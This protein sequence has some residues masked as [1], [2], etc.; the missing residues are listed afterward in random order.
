M[1]KRLTYSHDEFFRDTFARQET[2]LDFLQHY[3]P[4]QLRELVYLPSLTINKDSFIDPELQPHYADLL[5]HLDWV[6]STAKTEKQTGLYLYL[7]FEHK[8]HPDE[9]VPLQLLTYQ[10]QIWALWRKQQAQMKTKPL[11]NKLPPILPIVFYHGTSKWQ[12]ARNF[13]ALFDLPAPLRPHVPEFTYL[14]Y[15]LSEYSDTEIIG[16]VY[17]RARLLLMKY[18]LRDELIDKLDEIFGL[19]RGLEQAETGM[20]H[21]IVMLRYLVSGVNAEQKTVL[22]EKVNQAML[23][24]N[25]MM[26]IADA[27][28]AEGEAKGRAAGEAKGRLDSIRR[29][30]A[31]RFEIP[32]DQFDPQL[33]SLD[34]AALTELSEIMFE[35]ANLTEFEAALKRLTSSSKGKAA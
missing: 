2:A 13:Q 10:Q 8:S 16:Q 14:L 5:Y 21:L 1:P 28:I 34:L 19:L 6:T 30:M 24:D 22:V 12:T 4:P 35:V 17:L 23:G 9:W 33:Q 18:I 29:F 20:E 32:L 27:F 3:L 31:Y 7:L 15:D 25:I 11:P 26:T